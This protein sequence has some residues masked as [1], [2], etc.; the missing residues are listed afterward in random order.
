MSL[1]VQFF[2]ESK[3][4]KVKHDGQD[5]LQNFLKVYPFI[6]DNVQPPL[7]KLWHSSLPK[8]HFPSLCLV[9]LESQLFARLS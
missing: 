7:D 6:Y 3:S 2:L 5:D 8:G 4:I 9:S 1:L